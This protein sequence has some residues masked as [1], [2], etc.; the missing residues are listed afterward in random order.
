MQLIFMPRKFYFWVGNKSVGSRLKQGHSVRKENNKSFGIS[1]LGNYT[2]ASS[3]N[4]EVPVT[5]PISGKYI[6][7]QL[8]NEFNAEC[9]P[10][11][12]VSNL[13]EDAELIGIRYIILRFFGGHFFSDSKMQNDFTC[14]SD[15]VDL[16]DASYVCSY[17]DALMWFEERI[18]KNN[19]NVNPEFTRC[20]M[21]GKVVLP[22]ISKPPLLLYNLLHGIDHRSKHFKENIRAYNSMFAF[23]SIGGKVESAVNNGGGPPQF[24]LSGQNYHRIGTLLPQIGQAPKFAQLYIYD[25]QNENLNRMK[26]FM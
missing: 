2:Q 1:S 25:T 26:P 3:S 10:Q 23:T 14:L 13:Y 4:I 21:K 16:G 15:E 24:V 22:L 11:L 8:M 18:C 7:R 6:C 12:H 20:C 17:C 19:R 5:F 9:D